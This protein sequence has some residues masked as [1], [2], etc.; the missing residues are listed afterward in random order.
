MKNKL[1]VIV[2]SAVLLTT[3]ACH[4]GPPSGTN[5]YKAPAEITPENGAVISGFASDPTYIHENRKAD[6][7]Y[8]CI[9]AIDGVP[10]VSFRLPGANPLLIPGGTEDP[11]HCQ[12]LAGFKYYLAPGP[13]KISVAYWDL[14]AFRYGY[15]LPAD[16]DISVRAGQ[17]LQVRRQPSGWSKTQVWIE[18]ASGARLGEIRQVQYEGRRSVKFGRI[19]PKLTPYSVV[20]SLT[21]DPAYSGARLSSI[22]VDIVLDDRNKDLIDPLRQTFVARFKECGMA[23]RVHTVIANDNGG[24]ESAGDD[25]TGPE[26]ARAAP[27]SFDAKLT[28]LEH[29][30]TYYKQRGLSLFG[31]SADAK[32]HPTDMT[33]ET[34]LTLKGAK[35]PAWQTGA[36]VF[37]TGASMKDIP[38]AFI[39]RLSDDGYLQGCPEIPKWPH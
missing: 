22:A 5:I 8:A 19:D 23:A 15:G 12:T 3:A 38:D 20:P 27:Q 28:I 31:N 2:L 25:M 34:A 21:P 10:V 17:A 32:Q 29:G 37:L 4:S 13:H 11:T 9:S 30:F 36:T 18:D 16:I 1:S 7:D 24:I 26:L 35:S 39:G 33:V 14:D 6:R